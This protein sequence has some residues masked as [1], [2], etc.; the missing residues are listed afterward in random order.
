MRAVKSNARKQNLGLT[1]P[2]ATVQARRIADRIMPGAGVTVESKG[3][4]DLDTDTPVIITTVTF[5]AN[6]AATAKVAL[7]LALTDLAGN[8]RQSDADSSITITRKK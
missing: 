1:V 3:S 5:P 7:S 8:I 2:A 6:M 4:H